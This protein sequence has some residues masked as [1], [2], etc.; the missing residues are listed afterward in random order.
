MMSLTIRSKIKEMIEH[1]E[2]RKVQQGVEEGEQA[3][4]PPKLDQIVPT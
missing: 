4:H 2:G 3:Q 1:H